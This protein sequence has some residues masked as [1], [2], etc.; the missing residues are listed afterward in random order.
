MAEENIK[1]IIELG[2]VKIKCIIF[3]NDVNFKTEILSSSIC[4]SK[5]IHN[6][7]IVNSS[8]IKSDAFEKLF[9]PYGKS[10]GIRAKK[11]HIENEGIPRSQKFKYI[12]KY[13]VN[14][15]KKR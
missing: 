13:I 10:I 14:S 12:N 8:N 6:G 11:F 4:D 15:K 2:N 7:V 5:G 9:K 3:K 1:A